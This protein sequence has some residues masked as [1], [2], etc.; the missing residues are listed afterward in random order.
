MVAPS[1]SSEVSICN[2]AL[3]HCGQPPIQSIDNPETDIE[4]TLRDIYPAVRDTVLRE[5]PWNFAQALYTS[6]KSGDGIGKWENAYDLP[7]DFIRLNSVGEDFQRP[8]RNYFM[9][10]NKIYAN[11][12]NSL[13]IWYN[14]RVTD[15]RIMDVGFKTY[16]ALRVA[17]EVAPA[18][19]KKNSVW[20]RINKALTLQEP[21]TFGTD[22][23]ERPPTRV[24]RS[25]YLAARRGRGSYRTNTYADL[26][27]YD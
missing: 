25:K 12:G 17:L 20:E 11:A 14:K 23:Q 10:D 8:N 4:R 15:V 19:T 9:G 6:L 21:K 5:H 16:L 7:S 26:D 27:S 1:P 13:T 24:Q 3:Y 22:G 18:V 2:L